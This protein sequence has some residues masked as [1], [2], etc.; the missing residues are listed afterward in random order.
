VDMYRNFLGMGCF[1]HTRKRRGTFFRS[2]CKFLPRQPKSWSFKYPYID[3]FILGHRVTLKFA[4][5]PHACVGMSV[6]HIVTEPDV[7]LSCSQQPGDS[8]YSDR[9]KPS[10]YSPTPFLQD[11]SA[12]CDSHTWSHSFT[13]SDHYVI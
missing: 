5:H 13:F 4:V 2:A 12:I 9:S 3:L 10:P 8:P 7:S 6:P 1:N 11:P